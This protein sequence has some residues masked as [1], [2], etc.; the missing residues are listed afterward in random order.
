MCDEFLFFFFDITDK[1]SIGYLF[2]FRYC[3]FL[4][5]VYGVVPSIQLPTPCASRPSLLAKE[6][7]F[8]FLSSPFI[9]WRYS[10]A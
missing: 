3:I 10:W 8:V 1:T 7:S 9:R 4:F 6:V 5:E 2:V